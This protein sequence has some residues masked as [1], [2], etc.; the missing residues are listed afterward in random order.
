MSVNGWLIV[1]EPKGLFPRCIF[2][3]NVQIPHGRGQVLDWSPLWTV[4]QQCWCTVLLSQCLLLIE[5]FEHV[6]CKSVSLMISER[7]M[8]FVPITGEHHYLAVFGGDG[9]WGWRRN[10]K[11]HTFACSFLSLGQ[12]SIS[13]YFLSNPISCYVIKELCGWM[14][15]IFNKSVA[16]SM[17]SYFTKRQLDYFGW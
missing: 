8:F 2:K 6:T 16:T 5:N 15:F 1:G 13:T 9:R 3:L 7:T 11:T 14:E 4:G 12:F 10:E 17:S